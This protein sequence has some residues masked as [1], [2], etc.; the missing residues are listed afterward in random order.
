M[1]PN[2]LRSKL[3]AK[4]SEKRKDR[5]PKSN[6]SPPTSDTNTVMSQFYDKYKNMTVAEQQNIMKKMTTLLQNIKT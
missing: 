2:S 5:L 4:I 3:R 1:D 6:V